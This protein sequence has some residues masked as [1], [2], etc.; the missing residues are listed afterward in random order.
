MNELELIGYLFTGISGGMMG[1]IA[2]DY[3]Q[4]TYHKRSFEEAVSIL[5]LH[6]RMLCENMIQQQEK[7]PRY[8]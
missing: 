8:Q 3:I 2:Y 7:N 6:Q 1:S 4:R 5:P